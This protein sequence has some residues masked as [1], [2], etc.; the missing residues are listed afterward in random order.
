MSSQPLIIIGGAV[1]TGGSLLCRLLDGNDTLHVYP[2]EIYIHKYYRYHPWYPLL[3]DKKNLCNNFNILKK[4]WIDHWVRISS[5]GKISKE[6]LDHVVLNFK[7]EN[8]LINCKQKLMQSENVISIRDIY[9][10]LNKSFFENIGCN[11][12]CQYFVA[13]RTELYSEA[14]NFFNIYPD[15]YFIHT[16]RDLKGF[17]YS[18]KKWA[19]KNG[20]FNID[21]IYIVKA[22]LVALEIAIFNKLRYNDRYIIIPHTLLIKNSSE[23]MQDLLNKMSI[24]YQEINSYPSFANH[25][26]KGNMTRKDINVEGKVNKSHLFDWKDK[27]NK[28]EIQFLNEIEAPFEDI[29]QCNDLDLLNKIIATSFKKWIDLE[30]QDIQYVFGNMIKKKHL[31]SKKILKARYLYHCVY[32]PR[33]RRRKSIFVQNIKNS[34]LEKFL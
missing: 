26:W 24:Y 2:F 4:I 1:R 10:I 8:F 23:V 16:L 34:L 11:N 27:L 25:L 17:C 5:S 22:W 20:Y 6:G 31:S 28:K 21:N 12:P 30:F 7:K 13:H 3:P 29:F 33:I 15:G 32:G 14:K 9:D 19:E 18:I